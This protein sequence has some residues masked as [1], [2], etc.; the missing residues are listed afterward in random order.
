MPGSYA[1]YG[2]SQAQWEAMSDAQREAFLRARTASQPALSAA[3]QRHAAE[4]LIAAS[5]ARA[6]EAGESDD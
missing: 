6:G 5:A 3:Q 2:I 1:P 4:R